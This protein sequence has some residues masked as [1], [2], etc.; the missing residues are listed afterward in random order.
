MRVPGRRGHPE[1]S[2]PAERNRRPFQAASVNKSRAARRRETR[3]LREE[4]R[5]QDTL[6]AEAVFDAKYRGH[7][8]PSKCE[9]DSPDWERILMGRAVEEGLRRRH[10]RG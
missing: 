5:R 1:S 3:E 10:E 7:V 6:A 8:G 9:A 2:E 4:N